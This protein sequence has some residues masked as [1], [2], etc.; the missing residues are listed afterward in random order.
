MSNLSGAGRRMLETG[1]IDAAAALLRA[2]ATE[3]EAARAAEAAEAAAAEAAA[4][5]AT[6]AA[7]V[8]GLVAE[9]VASVLTR[10]L[11]R[12]ALIEHAGLSELLLR[13]H[14][15]WSVLAEPSPL[16]A[17]EAAAN[18]LAKLLPRDH[19]ED[20]APN[21]EEVTGAAA[22]AAFRKGRREAIAT[23]GLDR[24]AGWSTEAIEAW[25]A[26]EWAAPR[27]RGAA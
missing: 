25:I 23:A 1:L 21:P 16:V 19:R 11:G 7:S 15:A 6:R 22:R 9:L 5:A 3:A 17:A 10:P 27:A 20:A 18:G 24:E 26:A 13:L 12:E 2:A 8:A 14:A 4:E